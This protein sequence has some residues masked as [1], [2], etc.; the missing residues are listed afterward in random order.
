MTDPL[1]TDRHP[2]GGDVPE[3]NRDARIEEQQTEMTPS[4]L[5]G[6]VAEIAAIATWR[7]H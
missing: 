5:R 6:A 1:R 7:C 3:R 4:A 2:W